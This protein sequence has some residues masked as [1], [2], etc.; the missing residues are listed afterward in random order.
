M[1]ITLLVD[2]VSNPYSPGVGTHPYEVTAEAT[3]SRLWM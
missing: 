3:K 1:H 2:E